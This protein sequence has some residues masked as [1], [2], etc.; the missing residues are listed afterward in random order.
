MLA[1]R[2]T[3]FT[4]HL[5]LGGKLGPET[6]RRGSSWGFFWLL[7]S[8]FTIILGNKNVKF[9]SLAIFYMPFVL[10]TFVSPMIPIFGLAFGIFTISV[11]K[12]SEKVS[13]D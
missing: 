10:V 4:T 9:R 8:L 5:P 6:F 7:P 11:M 13:D 2:M 1:P 3:A 12:N